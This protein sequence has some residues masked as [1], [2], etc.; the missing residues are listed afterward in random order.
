MFVIDL[1]AMYPSSVYLPVFFR[2]TRRRYIRC[3]DTDMPDRNARKDEQTEIL[4]QVA[5]VSGN[6]H[7][8][9]P[10]DHKEGRKSTSVGTGRQIGLSKRS[11]RVVETSIIPLMSESVQQQNGQLEEREKR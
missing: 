11:A 3:E 10:S 1:T 5:E 6:Q 7:C 4:H 8:A 2:T 9:A